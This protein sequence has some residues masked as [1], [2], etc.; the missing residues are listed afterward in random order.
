MAGC[1]RRYLFKY[2]PGVRPCFWHLVVHGKHGPKQRCIDVSCRQKQIVREWMQKPTG[3]FWGLRFFFWQVRFAENRLVFFNRF[4]QRH[5][6]VVLFGKRT[7]VVSDLTDS[8]I[9]NEW[10]VNRTLRRYRTY[11]SLYLSQ[12]TSR[13]SK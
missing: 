11:L 4:I 13:I 9:G 1:K 2:C 5:R 7:L 6:D 3:L 8:I 10:M 12:N